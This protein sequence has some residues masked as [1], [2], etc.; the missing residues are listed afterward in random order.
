MVD[1]KPI[2]EFLKGLG[3]TEEEVKIYLG[4]INKGPQTVLELSRVVKIPRTTLYRQIERL[5]KEGV[6]EEIIDQYKSKVEAVSGDRFEH[7]V[8][9]KE[10]QIAKLKGLLPEVLPLFQGSQ[11]INQPGTKVLFYRGVEGIKQM[12]WNVLRCKEVYR[13]YTFQNWQDLVGEELVEQW[14]YEFE[15]K[16]I[17]AYDLCSDE[18]LQNRLKTRHFG[19][20]NNWERRYIPSK[21][22]TIDHQIDIY[23]DVVAFYHWEDGEVFGVEIHNQK[24]ANLQKQIFDIL[25]ESAQPM[26]RTTKDSF[27]QPLKK[28]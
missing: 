24:I 17:P 19:V 13:G 12:I 1:K 25:F 21:K 27:S 14:S 6:I 9:E 7:L 4:L 10:Y 11:S 15:A 26:S 2:L 3:L 23:N 8:R 5:K 16:G 18:Y 22:L 20:W 28:R